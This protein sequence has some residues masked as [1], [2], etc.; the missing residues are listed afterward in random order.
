LISA[1]RLFHAE[2]RGC[3]KTQDGKST[4]TLEGQTEAN[5]AGIDPRLPVKTKIRD[6]DR[7][8]QFCSSEA[9]PTQQSRLFPLCFKNLLKT[10]RKPG[11]LYPAP[12]AI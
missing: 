2:W 3:R 1:E 10:Q 12:L 11:Y 7:L 6:I 4:H 5:R 9:K 8:A